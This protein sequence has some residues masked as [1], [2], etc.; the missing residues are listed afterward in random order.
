MQPRGRCRLQQCS[1]RARRAAICLTRTYPHHRH[2]RSEQ[3][4][5]PRGDAGRCATA[6]QS[7]RPRR[8]HSRSDRRDFGGCCGG[9]ARVVKAL[10]HELGF[11]PLREL[12]QSRAVL[13]LLRHPATMG[14]PADRAGRGG[15]RGAG[16]RLRRAPAVRHSRPQQQ[17]GTK[18][19]A[20]GADAAL[21]RR[22]SPWR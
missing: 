14:D 13:C 12:V 15:V 5:G 19:V 11:L 7:S 18:M 21:R 8:D 22:S 6:I 9:V 4:A 1:R 10:G 17:D 20:R 16:R 3:P 2:N